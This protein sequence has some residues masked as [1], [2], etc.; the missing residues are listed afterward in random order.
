[1]PNSHAGKTRTYYPNNT[2]DG[3]K[4]TFWNAAAPGKYPDVL[5]IKLPKAQNIELEGITILSSEDGYIQDFNVEI[6]P[7]VGTGNTAG[8][9]AELWLPVASIVGNDKLWIPVAFIGFNTMA[10]A[11]KAV[12]ITVTRAQKTRYGEY[13]RIN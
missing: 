11:V 4:Q 7:A 2:I 10:T 5:T 6:L 3:D 12:R 1:Q 9:S 13:T 8:T